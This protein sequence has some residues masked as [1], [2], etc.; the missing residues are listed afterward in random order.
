VSGARTKR[1]PSKREQSRRAWQSATA[2]RAANTAAKQRQR[3]RDSFKER[4]KALLGADPEIASIT[5][6]AHP[7]LAEKLIAELDQTP[8]K[9]TG[10]YGVTY[11]VHVES[12]V[13]AL[14]KDGVEVSHSDTNQWLD[15][16][17]QHGTDRLVTLATLDRE[18][19]QEHAD[20]SADIN[21]AVESGNWS[22]MV[23]AAAEGLRQ[24]RL[25][26]RRKRDPDVPSAEQLIQEY[27]L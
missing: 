2:K 8:D 13:P 12:Q 5:L 21:T 26:T 17:I 16:V 1:Q 7:E 24:T 4:G 20:H 11:P 27:G 3:Q 9:Q 25:E 14:D 19:R 15:E 22:E 6:R 18:D 23:L 10:G